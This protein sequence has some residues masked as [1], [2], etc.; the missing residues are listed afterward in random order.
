M[1]L[2]RTH[3]LMAGAAYAAACEFIWHPSLPY[4]ATGTAIAAGAGVLPDLDTVGSCVARSFGWA[5]ELLAGIVRRVSGG[6]REYTHTGV[7][8]VICAL[9]AVAAIALEP[10]HFH[11]HAGPVYRELSYGRLLLGAYLALLFSAGMKALRLFHDTGRELLAVAAAV[12][13]AW[14]GWDAHG[15]AWAIL[16]GT[17]IHAAGD[18]LTKHGVR[19]FAPF[20]QREYHLLPVRLRLSTGHFTERAVVAPLLLVALG[21]LSWHAVTQ[22][23]ITI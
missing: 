1:C 20:S 4:L 15:I 7:G 2:G 21:F 8:D 11:V 6:H 17:A 3:A 12:A 13:M 9:I 22:A 5:S 19:Y 16:L 10:F 18:G 14:S 23:G